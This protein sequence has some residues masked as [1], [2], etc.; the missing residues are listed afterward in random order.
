MILT[1]PQCAAR[2]SLEA[3]LLAPNGR[4]VRCAACKHVWH[5]LPDP[6]ELRGDLSD[7]ADDEI[8]SHMAELEEQVAAASSAPS[9][10]KPRFDMED[11][12]K[13]LRP[14]NETSQREAEK[15]AK[16]S[17]KK[18]A[19]QRRIISGAAGALAVLIPAGALFLSLQSGIVHTWPASYVLYKTFGIAQPVAGEGLVF[20]KMKADARKN[21]KGEPVLHVEGQVINLKS[22]PVSVPMIEATLKGEAGEVLDHWLIAPPEDSIDAE[23]S[24]PFSAETPHKNDKAIAV[25][26]RFLAVGAAPSSM[27]GAEPKTVSEDDG[28][29]PAPPAG[30]TAHPSGHAEVS[31]SPEH[32]DAPPHPESQPAHTES[33][34]SHSG[35]H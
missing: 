35:H 33:S 25:N 15:S 5:Q 26:L 7:D 29:N 2:F 24:M 16:D 14:E 17:H 28:N 32:G 13:A 22:Y 1:C 11:I 12:P 23:K 4:K 8:A 3:E 27:V 20:D 19:L 10:A 18:K 6:A 9:S 21:L 31:E 34:E 30:G